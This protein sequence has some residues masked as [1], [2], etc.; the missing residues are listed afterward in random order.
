MGITVPREVDISDGYRFPIVAK[1]KKYLSSDLKV[2]TPEFL[3]NR[4]AFSDFVNSHRIE[5]FP[6]R[7]CYLLQV[8]IIFCFTLERIMVRLS[9]HRKI[10]RSNL[11]ESILLWL[12]QAIFI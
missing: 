6:I 4:G 10:M 2:F 8:A 9:Y 1:P 7:N 12:K 11:V 5:D 3:T